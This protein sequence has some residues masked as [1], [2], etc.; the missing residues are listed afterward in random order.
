MR[1]RGE[2]RQAIADAAKALKAEQG[3][4]TWRE[5]SARARVGFDLGHDTVRNMA[6]SGELA[7]VGRSQLAGSGHWCKLYEPA[8][9]GPQLGLDLE[10]MLRAWRV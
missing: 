4:A 9:P 1:P 2:A 6:R 8:P 10:R 7:V 5:L 3:A